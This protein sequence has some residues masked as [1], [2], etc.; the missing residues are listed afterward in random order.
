[1]NPNRSWPGPN[2][3]EQAHTI[4]PA[5]N[6]IHPAPL[7]LMNSVSNL[8]PIDKN[9]EE[10]QGAKKINATRNSWRNIVLEMEQSKEKYRARLEAKA[11]LDE[12][13]KSDENVTAWLDANISPN[14]TARAPGEGTP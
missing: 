7:S 2:D 11:R 14:E 3:F 13:F 1:M 8:A 12:N 5:G 10:S 9:T 6:H 4:P